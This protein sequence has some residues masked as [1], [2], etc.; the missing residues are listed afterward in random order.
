[1]NNTEQ[2]IDGLFQAGEWI[3]E[4]AQPIGETEDGS[5]KYESHIEHMIE[6]IDKAIDVISEKGGTYEQSKDIPFEASV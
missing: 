4:I 2:I 6:A 1:M 5:N 3:T